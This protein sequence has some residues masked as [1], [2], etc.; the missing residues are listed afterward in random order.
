MVT[1]SSQNAAIGAT[2]LS[3][4]FNVSDA[5]GD[6]I[7]K[8]RFVDTNSDPASGYITLNGAAQAAGT[9]VEITAL[10]LA[11]AAFF[12]GHVPDTVTVS[13]FDGKDWSNVV[14]SATITPPANHAPVVTTA[15]V[16][17]AKNQTLALSSLFS[18]NDA[19]GDTIVNGSLA[20]SGIPRA[21]ISNSG[22]FAVNGAAQAA[23]IDH[24]ASAPRNCSRPALLPVRSATAC[25]SAPSMAWIGVRLRMPPGRLSRFRCPSTIHRS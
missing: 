19:D 10:Q 23:G 13:A 15:T 5:D 18:V 11:Q 16:N 21:R 1:A 2:A 8:Y 9:V 14:A 7:T 17:A 12:V 25:R 6:T 4:L 22:H 3:G 24:R 20:S